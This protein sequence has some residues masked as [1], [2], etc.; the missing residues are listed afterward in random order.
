MVSFIL[1]VSVVCS[2]SNTSNLSSDITPL[3]EG[4][5][6]YQITKIAIPTQTKWLQPGMIISPNVT[7]SNTG[8]DDLR[9]EDLSTTAFLGT[10]PLLS[11]KN[12]FQ[13]L[14]KNE[15]K[16]FSFEFLIPSGVPSKEYQ[17]S[18]R[19]N[20]NLEQTETISPDIQAKSSQFVTI[21]SINPKVKISGC[22]CSK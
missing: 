13:P 20:S 22:A 5:P 4:E 11:N 6:L 15:T 17:L 19:I 1:I 10:Y 12:T 9:S 2:G 3:K 8:S 14:K 7:I 21:Q 18:I 16:V